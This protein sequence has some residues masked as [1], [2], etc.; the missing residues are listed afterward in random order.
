MLSGFGSPVGETV[1]GRPT[2]GV[3]LTAGKLIEWYWPPANW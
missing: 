2:D 3:V 1:G